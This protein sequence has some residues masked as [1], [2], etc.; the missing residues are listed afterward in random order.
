MGR[1]HLLLDSWLPP[2]Y[3]SDADRGSAATKF[4]GL[5]AFFG[6][7]SMKKRILLISGIAALAL[8]ASG[9]SSQGSDSADFSGRTV[10]I[11]V[12][13]AAGGGYDTYARTIAAHLGDHIPGNPTVIVE[14]MPGGGSLVAANQVYNSLA[15]DG[16]VIGSFNGGLILQQLLGNPDALFDAKNFHYLGA[17]AAETITCVGRV[18]TGVTALSQ[19]RDQAQPLIFGGLGPGSQPD[20]VATILRDF[21]DLELSIVTGYPGTSGLRVAMEQG[22][23][24]AGC[25]G[26]ESQRVILAEELAA[27][28]LIPLGQAALQAAPDAQGVELFD[29][30]ARDERDRQVIDAAIFGPSQFSRPFTLHPDTDPATVEVLQ[31]AFADTMADAAFLARAA[32]ANLAIA[33]I[34]VGDFLAAIRAVDAIDAGLRVQLAEVLI[35]TS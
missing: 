22:E 12:G 14:N 2:L 3:A 32:E 17:P 15:S 19:L 9:C 35:P 33:P 10:R 18:G 7:K 13:Y 25:W 8:V 1:G 34:S 16:T 27:G 30:L 28:L 31:K 20:D 24:D 26:W 11:V 4:P 6:G 21:L 29:A 23:V 5:G